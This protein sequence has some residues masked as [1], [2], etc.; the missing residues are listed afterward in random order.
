M[1]EWIAEWINAAG[2]TGIVVLMFLENVF[3]PIP[4]ELIMPMAGFLVSQGEMNLVG[5]IAAG[6]FG[7]ILGALPFYYAGK[8][9]GLDRLKLWADR[10]GRLFT[11]SSADI[12]ESHRW[13]E[14]YGIW[15]VLLCRLVPGVRSLISIPAGINNMHMGQF[16]L[17]STIG[18]AVWSTLLA[19]AGYVLGVNYSKV[20]VYVGPASK[21]ILGAIV[22]I[23]LYRVIT[24]KPSGIRGQV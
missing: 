22:L 23:Y 20:E 15:T 4:S 10:Y 17:Y 6:T 12:D 13:F 24:Y 19:I 3:P 14:K 7:T 9:L 11:V 1:F 21:V 2:Y 5:V 16:L 8:F 18:S